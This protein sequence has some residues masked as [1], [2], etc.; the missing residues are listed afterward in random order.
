MTVLARPTVED[1]LA[2]AVVYRALSLGLQ[3]PTS[4]RL[5]EV[6]ALEGFRAVRAALD[7]LHHNAEDHDLARAA[8][9]LTALAPP[10][11][12]SAAARFV[13]LFGHTARGLVSTCETEYGPDN[14]FNQP[15]QLADIAGYYLAFG[16]T[17]AVATEARVD[18]IACELEFMDFL[19]RKQ[20]VWASGAAG[21][22]GTPATR[23]AGDVDDETMEATLT[24]ERTFLRDH[25]GRF[26]RAFATRLM[27]EDPNGY[28]GVLAR[29]LLALLTA[30][31]TRVGVD[32]GPLDLAVRPDVADDTPMAC[33]S[34]DELIQIQRRP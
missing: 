13:H 31:C 24:A 7:Y 5:R 27:A 30:E 4:A 28:F 22:G 9:H 25:L 32:A 11:P 2:R 34:A 20:A 12:D 6:G 15:Q 8:S 17:P 10:D 16:L 1:A 19:S 18:H 29:V 3:A 33:G 14:L 21:N 23:A 26:G